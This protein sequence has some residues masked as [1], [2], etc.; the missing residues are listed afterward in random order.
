MQDSRSQQLSTLSALPVDARINLSTAARDAAQ[1]L[2]EGRHHD[3]FSFLGPHP[4]DDVV[5]VRV[6]LP[7]ARVV[8]ML[9]IDGRTVRDFSATDFD[10]LFVI[11]VEQFEPYL[12][13]IDWPGGTQTTP[14]PYAFGAL[15]GDVDLHLIAEGRHRELWRCLGARM[16]EIDHV[17][18]VRFAVWAP[19]AVRVSVVGDFN[20][21]DGRRHPMRLRHAAG[22]WEIFIPGIGAGE[23]Y[24]YEIV[25]R[26]GQLLPLK[27]DPVALQCEVPP[28][29]ASIV[30]DTAPLHWSDQDWM[31]RRPA[32]QTAKAPISIYEVHA[33]S[34]MRMEGGRAPSWSELSERLIPYV[35]DM[36]FTHIELMPI[37]EH[38]FG[39]SWGYQPLG[40]FAPSSRYGSPEEFARF[41]DR[42]HAVGL[43]VILDWVPAHFPEDAYGIV[44][45]DGT[46]LYEYA[47]PREGR[48]MDWNTVIYNFGRHEVRG[49]LIA[50]ALIWLEHFHA[51]GLRVDAVAS[52][53]YRNYSRRHGEWIANVYGGTENLEATAFL[54]ELNQTITERCPGAIMIAE[55]STA[56]SGVSQP[57]HQGGLGFD[58]KW[59]MGWMHDSLRYMGFDPIYRRFHH[60]EMTFSLVYAFSERFILPISHDEV[61]HGK[62]TLLGRMPGDT[63]QR[64]AN[65]RAF[66]AFMWTHPGKK[67]L[68]MGCEIAQAH[69]WNH[70]AQLDWG[71]LEDPMH[72]GVQQL[73]RDLNRLYRDEPALH[74]GDADPSG[75]AWLVGNDYAN[76]VFAYMRRA[77]GSS[78]LVVICNMTPV[79][80]RAYR[81]GV[82]EGG[83]W[84]ERL[85]SDSA[86]YG[87]ANN[88]NAGQVM[89]QDIASHGQPAMLELSLPPLGVLILGKA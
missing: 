78:P 62:A 74:V 32:L 83:V 82:P 40:L 41:V 15:L 8:R 3:P 27:A 56:W 85:N 37:T 14:D 2:I 88:G 68:F 38:P 79:V 26:N 17:H 1:R 10:G 25:G 20:A 75:F 57:V 50:S 72:R 9:S 55:E 84:H 12:L 19:N 48:H 36:G 28:L 77:E 23:R 34:W 51:D 66:L 24:K 54:R 52:M 35:L 59:N 71:A 70:D 18:G 73:V 29:T 6:Y 42:C 67:L 65:L 76:S 4:V 21:W 63:W 45:F 44:Q 39:G 80:R 7:S 46:A 11:E 64:F 47:D 13:Q 33:A 61:V 58:F 5:I 69:E 43:G 49:F 60:D 16:L 22:V 81:I 86:A 30:T 87:G 53:L 89:A 31:A